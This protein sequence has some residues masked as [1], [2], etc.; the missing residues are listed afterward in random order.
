MVGP[1]ILIEQEISLSLSTTSL[2]QLK[3][4]LC[5]CIVVVPC[6]DTYLLAPTYLLIT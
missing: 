2:Y 3:D 6:L 1:R 4:Q 5:R